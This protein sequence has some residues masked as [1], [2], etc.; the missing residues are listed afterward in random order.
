MCLLDS[1]SSYLASSEGIEFE[2]NAVSRSAAS[3]QESGLHWMRTE[4]LPGISKHSI[5][6]EGT[7]SQMGQSSSSENYSGERR[8]ACTVRSVEDI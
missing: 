6:V 8:G 3:W 5:L 4:D 1:C 7:A 2:S